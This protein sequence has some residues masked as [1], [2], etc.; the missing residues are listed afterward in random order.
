[1]ALRDLVTGAI[2]NKVTDFEAG[3][4]AGTLPRLNTLMSLT[5]KDEPNLIVKG[6]TSKINYPLV[7]K[8]E[9][10]IYYFVIADKQSKDYERVIAAAQVIQGYIAKKVAR[11]AVISN[12]RD[13][14]K[15]E[16]IGKQIYLYLIYSFK[17]IEGDTAQS[18]NARAVWVTLGNYCKIHICEKNKKVIVK[19]AKII[20]ILDPRIWVD[21]D[22]EEQ[23]FDDDLEHIALN[24]ILVA[25][26][27]D[28]K[29]AKT[30][31]LQILKP[32]E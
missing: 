15:K 17:Q 18:E 26:K 22:N 23:Y 7:V 20:N 28:L 29:K 5:D 16:G 31:G 25:D 12:L 19:N 3:D 24:R 32:I 2:A 14:T 6:K 1:M 11:I 30:T 13:T 4:E 10:D 27:L 8:K 9:A 21:E